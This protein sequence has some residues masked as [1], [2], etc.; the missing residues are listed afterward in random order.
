M[1]IWKSTQTSQVVWLMIKPYCTRN[2]YEHSATADSG[3]SRD[4]ARSLH[5]IRSSSVQ[6]RGLASVCGC[7]RI[8]PSMPLI[9]PNLV[10]N[11]SVAARWRVIISTSLTCPYAR[12]F[13][14][15]GI[16]SW[17]TEMGFCLISF[18][19]LANPFVILV[20]NVFET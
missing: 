9:N 3:R 20:T 7:Y 10:I 2:N 13:L 16:C 18:A 6:H 4:D 14:N 15:R 19:Q 1:I 11:Q 17:I 8:C 12:M 5:S